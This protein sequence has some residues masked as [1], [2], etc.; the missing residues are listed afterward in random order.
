MT[1]LSRY[2]DIGRTAASAQVRKAACQRMA[3]A[4]TAELQMA[5]VLRKRAQCKVA[6]YQ[7]AAWHSRPTIL[8]WRWAIVRIQAMRKRLAM[9]RQTVAVRW[10]ANEDDAD[11]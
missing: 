10:L 3:A 4:K 6:A 1:A 7:M 9:L 11:C 5:T 8:G 2:Q